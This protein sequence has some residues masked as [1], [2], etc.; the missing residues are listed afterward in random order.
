MK[1]AD[2]IL[3]STVLRGIRLTLSKGHQVSLM[4]PPFAIGGLVQLVDLIVRITDKSL[5]LQ[6]KYTDYH[7]QAPLARQAR[8]ALTMVLILPV[9]LSFLGW[10]PSVRCREIVRIILD[11]FV[12]DRVYHRGWARND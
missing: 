6:G 8:L 9:L 1:A 11:P 5:W 3:S 12:L 2:Q 7:D 10:R 4:D